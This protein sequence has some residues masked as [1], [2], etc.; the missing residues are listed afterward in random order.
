MV[1]FRKFSFISLKEEASSPIS[2]FDFIPIF[3][4]NLP[5]PIS[6]AASLS[7]VIG[8]VIVFEKIKTNGAAIIIVKNKQ[9]LLCIS[10]NVKQ[11]LILFC[12]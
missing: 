2:S 11:I 12:V 3:V 5:L 9:D 1:D 7:F 4:V 6:T 8:F 10:I